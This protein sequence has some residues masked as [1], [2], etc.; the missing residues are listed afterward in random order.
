MREAFQRSPFPEGLFRGDHVRHKVRN[1]NA[2]R[3]PMILSSSDKVDG[4][5]TP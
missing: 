5:M 1:G 4:R 2:R 3:I